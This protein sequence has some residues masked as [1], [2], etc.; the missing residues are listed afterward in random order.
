MRPQRDDRV[1]HDALP[2]ARRGGA[3]RKALQDA[4]QVQYIDTLMYKPKQLPLGSGVHISY[5]GNLILKY[6]FRLQVHA[7]A[8]AGCVGDGGAGRLLTE[9]GPGQPDHS[10][11]GNVTSVERNI[12]YCKRKGDRSSIVRARS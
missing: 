4:A 9:A 11:D 12:T 3:H 5:T 2:G 10:I 7:V 8:A 6:H 1:L